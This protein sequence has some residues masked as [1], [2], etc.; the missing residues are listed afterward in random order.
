M[1]ELS[2]EIGDVLYDAASGEEW[3]LFQSYDT[4]LLY[5]E[6]MVPYIHAA[7]ERSRRLG[8]ISAY[9][10]I[11]KRLRVSLRLAQAGKSAEFQLATQEA[12]NQVENIR[13]HVVAAFMQTEEKNT[14]E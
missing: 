7:Q 6:K 5:G 8:V 12:L 13:N 1:S 11:I 3:D 4:A 10:S 14:N 2:K 9:D